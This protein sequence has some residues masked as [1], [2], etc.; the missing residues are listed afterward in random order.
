MLPKAAV[1]GDPGIGFPHGT[2]DEAA[3]A[4]PAVALPHD[5]PGSL[6][7]AQVLGNGG[8]GHLKRLG[9][10][11]HGGIP[12]GES[13][14]DRPPGRVGERGERRIEGGRRIVNHVV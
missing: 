3:A 13:R 4:H 9:E 10:G 7:D 2:G 12:R 5:E 1:A 11:A 8:E 6:E 14:Q